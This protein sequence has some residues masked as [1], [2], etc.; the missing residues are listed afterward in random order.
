MNELLSMLANAYEAG[1]ESVRNLIKVSFVEQ[2][3]YPEEPNA[4]IR[5]LLPGTLKP[6][7][8]HGI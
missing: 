8:Q 6:L 1:G 7:L 3:P 4:E 2:L 5:G